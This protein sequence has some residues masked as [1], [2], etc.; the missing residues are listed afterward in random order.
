M[1]RGLL[2]QDTTAPSSYGTLRLSHVLI[3]GRPGRQTHLHLRQYCVLSL[4]RPLESLSFLVC[5]MG[6]TVIQLTHR[7]E[8]SIKSKK[9]RE[10]LRTVYS[11]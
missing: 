10:G 6:M 7:V 4:G 3:K 2:I 8:V 1:M 11:K 9:T 5:K